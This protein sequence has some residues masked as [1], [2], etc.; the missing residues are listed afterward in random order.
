M[1]SIFSQCVHTVMQCEIRTLVLSDVAPSLHCLPPLLIRWVICLRPSLEEPYVPR[2]CYY[3]STTIASCLAAA[4]A[5]T[6]PASD[7]GLQERLW[8]LTNQ[9]Q[10]HDESASDAHGDAY[11]SQP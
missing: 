3:C 1:P 10:Q 8:L 5:A 9:Q 6:T 2:F 7:G 4:T 11:S